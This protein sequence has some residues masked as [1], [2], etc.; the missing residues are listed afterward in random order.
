MIY[1]PGYVE[2][3]R[4]AWWT[5]T[6]NRGL[7]SAAEWSVSGVVPRLTHQPAQ[8]C[9]A[10]HSDCEDRP[11]KGQLDEDGVH[12]LVAPQQGVVDGQAARVRLAQDLHGPAQ[13]G[14][15]LHRDPGNRHGN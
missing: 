10:A 13:D 1:G 5:F 4:K 7:Q 3:F 14:P 9:S 15:A 6:H 11:L 12:R 8:L 2:A